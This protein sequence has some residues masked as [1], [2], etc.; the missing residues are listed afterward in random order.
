MDDDGSDSADNSEPVYEPTSP[1]PAG[2]RASSR[3]SSVMSPGRSLNATSPVRA[4]SVDSSVDPNQTP[5]PGYDSGCED[6]PV[7]NDHPSGPAAA[8]SPGPVGVEDNAEP[9]RRRPGK[10]RGCV[11]SH[12]ARRLLRE[13]RERE[14][15]DAAAAAKE[16]HAVPRLRMADARNRRR[17]KM[18]AA[19]SVSTAVPLERAVDVLIKSAVPSNFED[20][21]CTSISSSLSLKRH[22][23]A[24]KP[25][26]TIIQQHTAPTGR[27]RARTVS[28]MAEEASQE[29]RD[30]KQLMVEMGVLGAK[31]Y[32]LGWSGF[33][34]RLGTLLD[35]EDYKGK[36]FVE[37]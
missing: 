29:V 21:V 23:D 8:L 4:E 13:Y 17:D 24:P 22:G 27:L 2:S 7:R 28:T 30:Y 20:R 18:A 16:R 3:S 12:D 9:E 25:V 31:F 26:T 15:K 19:R 34:E 5:S 10:P 36:L 33:A 35:G 32:R 14:A 1:A 6:V 37:A 11:G